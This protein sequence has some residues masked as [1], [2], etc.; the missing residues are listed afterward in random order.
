MVCIQ[1]TFYRENITQLA[2]VVALQAVGQ[3]FE[4]PYLYV[5][6]FFEINREGKEEMDADSIHLHQ[7]VI[8]S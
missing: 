7:E 8:I 4:S 2:R 3:G 1:T 6:W 5:N